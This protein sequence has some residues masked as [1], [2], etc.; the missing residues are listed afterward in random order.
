MGVSYHVEGIR[1]PDEK[2]KKMAAAWKACDAVGIEPP[3]DVLDF[4]DGEEPDGK[5][6]KVDISVA[7]TECG[8]EGMDYYDVDLSKLP[9]NITIVRFVI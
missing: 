6:L 7:V 5:G 2:Y 3:E 4:F 9:K 8:P 1:P